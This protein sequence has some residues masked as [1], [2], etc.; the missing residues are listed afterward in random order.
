ML[1]TKQFFCPVV[2]CQL[3][4]E[5]AD[6]SRCENKNLILK[7]RDFFVLSVSPKKGLIDENLTLALLASSARE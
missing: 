5:V 3:L 4:R 1:R 7:K 2:F 6:G